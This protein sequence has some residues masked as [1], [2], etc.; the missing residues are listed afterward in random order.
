M[1]VI[2]QVSKAAELICN[3]VLILQIVTLEGVVRGFRTENIN[4]RNASVVLG[5]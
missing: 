3:N 5:R 4:K 2:F 1:G